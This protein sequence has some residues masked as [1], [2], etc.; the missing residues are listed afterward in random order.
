MSECLLLFLILLPI[1]TIVTEIL[2]EIV[3]R[4]DVWLH[5]VVL[6]EP[7]NIFLHYCLSGD[8]LHVSIQR[9]LFFGLSSGF[10]S[11]SGV[12]FLAEEWCRR[13]GVFENVPFLLLGRC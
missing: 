6:A 4:D 2:H 13:D 3:H 10:C 12:W 1:T 9:V 5:N 8:V 7:K 11:E